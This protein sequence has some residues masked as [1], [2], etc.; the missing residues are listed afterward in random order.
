MNWVVESLRGRTLT[1]LLKIKQH[2]DEM[3]ERFPI[4]PNNI[5]HDEIDGFYFEK[6]LAEVILEK[7]L[8]KL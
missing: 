1:D 7:K 6:V 4:D 8:E 3:N 2:T 5:G